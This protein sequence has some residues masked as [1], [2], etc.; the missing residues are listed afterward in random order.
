MHQEDMHGNWRDKANDEEKQRVA[1]L[2]ARIE[3]RKQLIQ[4]DRDEKTKI[5]RRCI[6]RVRREAGLE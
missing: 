6:R 1:V 4:Y 5:M 3:R 2:E